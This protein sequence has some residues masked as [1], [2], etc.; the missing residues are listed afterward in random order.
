MK[1]TMPLLLLSLC[2][3]TARIEKARGQIQAEVCLENINAQGTDLFFDIY[4]RTVPGSGGNLYLGNA[5]FVL[6]FNTN[7]FNKPVLSKTGSGAGFCAFIPTDPAGTAFTQ[8]AYFI[9]T[10]PVIIGNELVIN[11]NGPTPSNQADFDIQVARIDGTLDLHRLGRFRIS[12]LIDPN[13]NMGL[14]WKSTGPGLITKIFTLSNTQPFISTQLSD[15]DLALSICS[16]TDADNDGSCSDIDCD[17]ND[18]NVF[19]GAPEVCNNKDDD[20]DGMVDEGVQSTFY[21]DT[22]NDGYGDPVNTFLGCNAP[23]GYVANGNDCNDS[24]A[25]LT[26]PG[27]YCDDG[28]PN[29]VD[30]IVSANCICAGISLAATLRPFVLANAGSYQATPDSFSLSWTLG[31]IAGETL[32]IM[33]GNDEC[34]WLRQDFQQPFWPLPEPAAV[35]CMIISAFKLESLQS[36]VQVFPNPFS[37]TVTIIFEKAFPHSLTLSSAQGRIIYTIKSA[38]TEDRIELGA[39]PAGIYLLTVINTP[40]REILSFKIIKH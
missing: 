21:A 14:M 23:P 27:N 9:N 17:D 22:D 5:D 15:S 37:E 11:L 18:L 20:C 33:V 28:N 13:G 39:L 30:D 25:N 2:L 19:P 34:Y 4:L 3:F 29:T 26:Q 1:K 10:S 36:D 7:N 40:N 8:F 12:G 24:D 32:K 16:C 35:A 31:Q 6:T 38:G